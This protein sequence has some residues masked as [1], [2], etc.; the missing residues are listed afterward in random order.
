[1]KRSIIVSLLFVMIIQLSAT[2]QVEK[3][4]WILSFSGMYDDS[5]KGKLGA[6]ISGGEKNTEYQ[7]GINAGYAI[8][9]RLIVGLSFAYVNQESVSSESLSSTYRYFIASQLERE[10]YAFNPSAFIKYY[11]NINEKWFFSITLQVGY[12]KGKMDVTQT[13]A[14]VESVITE[15]FMAYD[16]RDSETYI[17]DHEFSENLDIWTFGLH[18]EINYQLTKRWGLQAAV[19]G[20]TYTIVDKDQK[21]F[22]LNINPLDWEYGV[23]MKF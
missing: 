1:M 22:R 6:L 13:N 17:T 15:E 5:Q 18:P 20:I 7:V 21:N 14:Y 16:I 10:T 3:G 2:A 11:R 8:G 9:K 19:G 4:D 12:I 23:F